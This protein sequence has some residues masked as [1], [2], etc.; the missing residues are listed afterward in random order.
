MRAYLD[1]EK[2]VAA[3]EARI[4]EL[5]SAETP[6]NGDSGE[7]IGN[8][9]ERG[10]NHLAITEKAENCALEYDHRGVSRHALF[11]ASFI[12][13]RVELQH[14]GHRHRRRDHDS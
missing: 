11:C 3:L 10:E 5:R 4:D 2:P 14:P 13:P 1:F 9:V 6:K 7:E 12:R 8:A